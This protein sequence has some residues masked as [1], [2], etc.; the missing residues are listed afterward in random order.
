MVVAASLGNR[1]EQARYL[2]AIQDVMNQTVPT[3]DQKV[4]MWPAD[5][6]LCLQVADYCSW[7]IQ[8]KWE[9]SD[10]RSYELIQDK[11]VM[12]NDLFNVGTA[13]YY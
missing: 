10:T 6:D 12:E 11:V 3:S 5:S 7:A 13:L 4:A 1:R 2:S 9:R 8:R